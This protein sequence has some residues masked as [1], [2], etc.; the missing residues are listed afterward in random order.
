M[1]Y[2]DSIDDFAEIMK[3]GNNGG[4][5][6]NWLV[7]DRKSNEIAS[8]ELGLK[9]VTLQR[10]KDGY[11]CGANF[12]VNEKLMK[13]ETD[14]DPAKLGDSANARRVR[15]EELM[16]EYK[17]KIDVAAGQK[18]L[19]DHWDT[20][21]KKEAPSERTL[22]GHVDL[23]PRGMKG[24]QEPYGPAGTGQAKVANASM[25]GEMSFMAAM[26]HPCGIDFKAAPHLR[27]HPQFKWQKEYL[28]DL[29]SRPWTKFAAVK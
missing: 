26:G 25:A 27:L 6:N 1:Q 4:Y 10:T 12:P 2:S 20:Y 9:N 7:A 29:D 24:W 14:F 21:E 19:S 13:E 8:L 15:W 3:T 22:C 5:A 28:R 16:A 18:F 11:F 17:G 23:S